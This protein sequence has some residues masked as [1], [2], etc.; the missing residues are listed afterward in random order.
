MRVKDEQKVFKIYK[1]T[2]KLIHEIGIAGITMQKIS[3]EAGM[4]IGTVYIYFKNKNKLINQLY[5][6]L[7]EKSKKSFYE[8]IDFEGDFKNNLKQVWKNYLL[9]RLDNH[10]ESIF[11]EQY[12]RSPFI[13]KEE[14]KLYEDLKQPFYQL[15]DYGKS[16]GVVQDVENEMLLCVLLGFLRE[17]SSEHVEK[18]FSLNDERIERA[19]KISWN[20]LKK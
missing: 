2:L 6:H 1:A 12:Y 16:Q 5:V 14:K 15:L 20:S 17:L 4:A 19:F 18:K 11:L 7:Y 3:K 9:N 10:E 8:G 13:T